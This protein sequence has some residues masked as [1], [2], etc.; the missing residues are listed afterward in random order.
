MP[1][2]YLT[3]AID[4]ANGDPHLG[5]A[6]EK[7]GADVIARYRRLCG[8]D[9]HLLIGMDE[10]GQKVQ[11]T[12]AKEGVAPQAFTDEIAG[13]F[14][15]MWAKLG[16]SYDQFIRTT[17]AHHKDGVSA[18]IR[19]IA[20]RS[21]D[22]FYERSYTGMYCVGCE[23]FKQDA[24]IV[25][26]T[27]VLHPTRTLEEVEE[28]NWFFR[29]SKYQPFLQELLTTNPS[30][31]E[32]ES[33]RNEILGL[34][35]Q[36]LEDISA[37]RA[38]LEWAVPFPLALS[39]G[40]TQ[41]TYVWFDALPNYLT[42]T[43]FPDAGYEARWP[44]DLHIIGKDITRF[45]VVIWPAMLQAAGLPLP[46]Q[47]WAHGFVQL[48]GERFSK[49]AG[50]KLDLGEAVDRFGADAFRYVLLREVPFDGDGNFS[51]ERFEER[52]TADLANN[53]GNLASRAIAMVEKYCDGVVPSASR[54][55]HEEGDDAEIATYHRAMHGDAGWLLHDGLSA[56][57]R[58]TARA[59]EYTAATAPW[60][61]AKDPA[62]RAELEQI[63]ASLIRR[64]AR[65][66]VL[67]APFMPTKV[68]QVWQ[69]LGGPGAVAEQRFEGLDALDVGGWTVTKGEPLFPRP[70]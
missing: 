2:F 9:V 58:L 66:T 65:Q 49:S 35:A 29:L 15:A 7:I 67:L 13:R 34:L 46:K 45:H 56:V 17:E 25:D 37:S 42:A 64:I 31:C 69:Q 68:E 12:A 1:R 22:D 40:E 23:A 28:R 8:D 51:W 30:F 60:A 11:Q 41:G 20:E 47:V 62:R 10:H 4:Y 59:N 27:C 3:T 63:L 61:V 38:R 57:Y 70:A 16:V 26:G 48:G 6:L 44:A 53:F 19:R 32:P 24:D 55:A 52:Y 33:R 39:N 50:V 54:P 43:G 18:L 14:K 36:G 21:P 5:H